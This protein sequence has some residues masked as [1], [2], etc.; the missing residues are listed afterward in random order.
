M[1]DTPH[2]SNSSRSTPTPLALPGL[3]QLSEV[4]EPE[5]ARELAERE[6]R[7]TVTLPV[8]APT[9][10]GEP[11]E[12]KNEDKIISPCK[13]CR[14]CRLFEQN[15]NTFFV[16]KTATTEPTVSQ[17]S[18]L[19][20][21]DK[22][23]ALPSHLRSSPAGLSAAVG[24]RVNKSNT[25]SAEDTPLEPPSTTSTTPETRFIRPSTLSRGAQQISYSVSDSAPEFGTPQRRRISF[26]N[27]RESSTSP[28]PSESCHDAYIPVPGHVR[29][30]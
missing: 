12:N 30:G 10:S 24:T 9:S 11:D 5:S 23:S 7:M 13:R 27:D 2:P 3:R 14:F 18:Q 16:F 8:D 26:D 28:R 22:L 15:Y 4:S 29:L 20:S 21:S 6:S 17:E 1:S 25:S 19:T